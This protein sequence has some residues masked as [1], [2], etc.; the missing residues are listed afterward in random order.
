MGSSSLPDR[1]F[2]GRRSDWERP[3]WSQGDEFL[4][5]QPPEYWLVMALGSTMSTSSNVPDGRE[6]R[7]DEV[8][9]IAKHLS[10]TI[11][12]S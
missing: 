6:G 9:N 11:Q 12:L 8:S 5:I 10:I 3:C 1:R 2:Q 4:L 7:P